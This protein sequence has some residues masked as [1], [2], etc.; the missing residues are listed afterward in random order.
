MTQ[1]EIFNLALSL[2]DREIKQADLD[3]QTPSKEVRLCKV[4][5]PVAVLKALREMDWSF[6]TQEL[7]VDLSDDVSGWGYRHGYLL[8]STLFKH[9][10]LTDDPFQI[11]G[12]R[13]YT[14]STNPVLYGMLKDCFETMEHPEE[15]DLLVGYAISYEICG[16]LSPK[17]GLDQLALQQ[18]SWIL[19]ALTTAEVHNNYRADI[20]G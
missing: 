7:T 6:F 10:P 3:S 20:R 4:Y 5:Q 14:N 2:H 18:Y 15:F 13:Y 17:S 11:A 8:P 19:A 12:G 16:I 9:V 1:L